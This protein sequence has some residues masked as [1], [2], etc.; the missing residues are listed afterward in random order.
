[1]SSGLMLPILASLPSANVLEE[2]LEGENTQRAVSQFHLVSKWSVTS[3]QL[4]KEVNCDD[5]SL[6]TS[7][8]L[9]W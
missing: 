7:G 4:S 5:D 6:Q 9:C 2:S 8:S 1:M 3:S